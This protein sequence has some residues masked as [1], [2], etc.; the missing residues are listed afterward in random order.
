MILNLTEISFQIDVDTGWCVT[1]LKRCLQQV[2][3]GDFILVT[4][5]SVFV[6]NAFVKRQRMLVTKIS[7]T[8]TNIS[9]LSQ[10]QFS[11]KTPSEWT[12]STDSR[13]HI[14]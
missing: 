7:E 2:D 5:F 3:V 4:I 9:K 11:H 14:I 10:H 6:P 13:A 8:V 1:R 12:V